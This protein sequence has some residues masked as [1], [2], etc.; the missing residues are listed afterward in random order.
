MIGPMELLIVAVMAIFLI[1]PNEMARIMKTWKQVRGVVKQTKSE[2]TD[3]LVK[4]V[5]DAMNENKLN[6]HKEFIEPV[7][8]SFLEEPKDNKS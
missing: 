8:K 4:P 1:R 5:K 2:I 7:K 6:L 3:A